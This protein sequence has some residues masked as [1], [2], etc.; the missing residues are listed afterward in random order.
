MRYTNAAHRPGGT[1][2]PE[3]EHIMQTTIRTINSIGIA[4]I[5]AFLAANHKY[6][7]DHFTADMLRAWAEDAEFQMSEGNSPTVEIKSWD[8]VS[9]HTEICTVSEAGIDAVEVDGQ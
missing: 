7:G 4:E 1:G 2:I 6:G 9:G 8:A 5:H 3:K